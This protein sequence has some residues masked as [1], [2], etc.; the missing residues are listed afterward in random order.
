VSDQSAGRSERISLSEV[1]ELIE[2][3]ESE[4]L[5]EDKF[6]ASRDEV[7]EGT[8]RRIKRRLRSLNPDTN[9]AGDER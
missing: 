4:I 7:A 6:G 8:C 9:P 3:V 5:A 1:E 2:D